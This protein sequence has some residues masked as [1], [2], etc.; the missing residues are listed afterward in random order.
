[1]RSCTA[2]TRRRSQTGAGDKLREY[3][4]DRLMA[5]VAD[6]FAIDFETFG[7]ATDLPA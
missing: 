1:M 5:R 3:Y 6:R 2:S 7:Y 4:D